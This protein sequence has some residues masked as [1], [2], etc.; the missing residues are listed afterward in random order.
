MDINV[1]FLTRDVLSR[2]R[3]GEF[4]KGKHFFHNYFQLFSLP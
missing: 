2:L 1:C 3:V 4:S